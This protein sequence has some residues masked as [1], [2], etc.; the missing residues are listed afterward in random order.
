[1][2]AGGKQRAGTEEKKMKAYI[3]SAKHGTVQIGRTVYCIPANHSFQADREG[4]KNKP[5]YEVPDNCWASAK[6]AIEIHK[7]NQTRKHCLKYDPKGRQG[8]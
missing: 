3:I 2:Q 4:L 7:E 1:L 6:L 8:G 5:S